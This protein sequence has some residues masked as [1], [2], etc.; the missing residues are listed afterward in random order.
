MAQSSIRAAKSWREVLKL[1]PAAE[2][3]PPLSPSE[4][5]ELGE[6]IKTNGLQSPPLIW[7]DR[8]DTGGSR[9][10]LDGR[11]RLD[12]M[13]AVG[14]PVLNERGGFVQK[15]EEKFNV[16]SG[17][18]ERDGEWVPSSH[19]PYALVLSLNVRR[20]HLSSEQKR[21]LVAKI[22]QAKPGMSSRRVAQLVGVSPTT[23]ASGRR[24]LEAQ[25]D[26]SKL[27]TLTDT[28]GRQ[29]PARKPTSPVKTAADKAEAHAATQPRSEPVSLPQTAKPAARKKAPELSSLSW[30]EASAEQRRRFVDAI[31]LKSLFEAADLAARLAFLKTTSDAVPP[32]LPTFSRPP[33]SSAEDKLA[34]P[35]FLLRDAQR[36][37]S[38][39]DQALDH[40]GPNGSPHLERQGEA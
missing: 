3:F 8:V 38:Q 9:Y 23:V 22:L 1:H 13:E 20:R 35:D 39:G 25:G 7:V 10:L 15:I 6:D 40:G 36:A 28:K 29:Q 34:I 24:R 37:P 17:H 5:K 18:Y 33:A 12:A 2:L 21:E 4:L 27:D 14:L 19:D 16:V 30:S 26:V 32:K 31:G 11:N